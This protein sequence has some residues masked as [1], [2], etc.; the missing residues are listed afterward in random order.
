MA[1]D[2]AL[3]GIRV[4]D[5]G[6]FMAGPMAAM[7]LAD[8]GADVIKVEHPRG[9][10]FR[11]WGLTKDGA[12][13]FWKM[14]SRNKHCATLNLGSAKG[15]DL[16]REMVKKS[17]VLIENFTPGT[18]KKWGL[19]YES[20]SAIN[21]RLIML[22]ISAYGQSGPYSSRPGFGTLAEALSGYAHITGQADGP[23]TLPGFG[24]AD[25]MAGLNGAFGILLALQYRHVSG[26]GQHIDTSLCEP[27]ITLL[28][29]QV[30]EYDALGV[31]QERRGSRLPFSAPRNVYRITPI[32]SPVMK[33]ALSDA[34]TDRSSETASAI[35]PS[36]SLPMMVGQPPRSSLPTVT[37]PMLP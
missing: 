13:L 37:R 21:P 16:L 18:M 3:K 26:F 25:G 23:P 2:G 5:L 4:L 14:L 24:L 6:Q 20:L 1:Q 33:P 35:G 19:D 34:L 7:W 29:P 9:D 28:G 11:S 22:S 17:D 27:L 36:T 12:P 10:G 32:V 31:I 30:V 8:F 15:Q